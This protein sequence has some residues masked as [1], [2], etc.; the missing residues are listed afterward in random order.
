MLD[1]QLRR[2]GLSP[3]QPPNAEQWRVFV[4]RMEQA[5]GEAERHR[6]MLERSLTLSSSEM[7]AL[8]GS[9]Q[10]SEA[11][12]RTV[13]DR[14]PDLVFVSK[15]DGS[16]CY[17]NRTLVD[18]LGYASAEEL[19]GRPAIETLVPPED[20]Q[21][22]Y[23]NR[24]ERLAGRSPHSPLR[25]RRKDGEIFPVELVTATVDWDNEPAGVI[26]ARDVRDQRLLEEQLR[27]SHKMEAI[28]LLA[29]GVAHDFNNLLTVLLG[30]T[31]LQLDELPSDSPL[32]DDI[33]EIDRAAK[34]ARDLTRQ[35]LAFS[36]KQ[37]LRPKVIDL[38][39]AVRSTEK[40]LR[41]V[42]GR[43]IRLALRTTSA[44]A[45]VFADPGQLEQ[46]LLNLVVNARDAVGENGEVWIETAVITRSGPSADGMLPSES[47][48]WRATPTSS[49]NSSGAW[50]TSR[51]DSSRRARPAMRS[52]RGAP[53][54]D[55]GI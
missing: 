8:H 13:L 37:V 29:G 39:E 38:N 40:M 49:S 22:A 52:R 32:R 31:E 1:R 30:Y 3:E 6:Y 34:L 14:S 44:P 36:R 54:P 48:T 35:L 11:N 41:R 24:Q 25:F 5:Y 27:Q 15:E 18:A 26:M 43:D 9:L 12:L 50:W 28:G 16:L 46:V 21:C 47:G 4:Q 2:L 10:R 17:V 42:L 23:S 45:V 33:G 51:P 20:W 19:L 55:S 7:R 53:T